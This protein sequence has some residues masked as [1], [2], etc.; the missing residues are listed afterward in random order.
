MLFVAFTAPFNN[1]QSLKFKARLTNAFFATVNQMFRGS[2]KVPSTAKKKLN[3]IV[4][5]SSDN[6]VGSWEGSPK[7]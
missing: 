4:V 7:I 6:L 1:M 5:H 2:S 3:R